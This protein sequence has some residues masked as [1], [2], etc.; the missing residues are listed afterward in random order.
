[1]S[2]S[3]AS[4]L[5]RLRGWRPAM[6]AFSSAL[7]AALGCALPLLLGLFSGHSGFI[8]AATGAFMASLANPLQRLGML[9]MCLLIC[10]G[11]FSAGLGFWADSHP[12]ASAGLFAL[13]GLFFAWMQ[14]YGKEAAAFAFCLVACLCLGQGQHGVGALRSGLAVGVLFTVGGCWALFLAFGLRGVHGLRMW[15]DLP[16]LSVILRSFRRHRRRLPRY[17]W[18]L[19]AVMTGVGAAAVGFA[20]SY[21]DVTRSY[22]MTLTAF[23][24]LQL[25]P[26]FSTRNALRAA[27]LSLVV[28]L[29]I[30]VLGHSLQSP[31]HMVFAILL[32]VYVMRAF[33]ARR[34]AAFSVQAIVCFVLLAEALSRDWYF[35][36]HRLEIAVYGAGLA[37]G[38]ALL[39]D[40]LSTAGTRRMAAL[41]GDPLAG[42]TETPTPNAASMPAAESQPNPVIEQSDQRRDCSAA[43]SRDSNRSDIE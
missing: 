26:R 42:G 8:W 21:F 43:A 37:F 10:L 34:F 39:A 35:A 38:L 41:R 9:H 15:P 31:Q 1:M 40:W 2:Y 22:W 18:L 13:F 6:P 12:S 27:V 7:I 19:F 20:A 16:R 32:T 24:V 14:R 5:S 11:A 36:M 33:L 17:R 23:A 3:P 30:C 4:S 25:D 28:L 29:L